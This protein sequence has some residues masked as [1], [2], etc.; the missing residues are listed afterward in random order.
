MS[1]APRTN[2]AAGEDIQSS[3]YRRVFFLS[4]SAVILSAATIII[5][6]TTMSISRIEQFCTGAEL[7]ALTLMPYMISAA[8]A[9]ITAI[10]VMALVPAIRLQA[11]AKSISARLRALADG[12]LAGTIHTTEK[13]PHLQE[14]TNELNIATGSLSHKIAQWKVINRQQWELLES[15]RETTVVSGQKQLVMIIEQM[16]RNWEKIAVIED[17]LTT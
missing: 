15:M 7:V 1:F 6:N 14:L 2:I 12:D 13:A 3:V 16:E 8:V 11:P 10:G 5:F 17:E 9:A 4:G